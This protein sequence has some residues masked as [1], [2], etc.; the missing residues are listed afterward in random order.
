LNKNSFIFRATAGDQKSK[1]VSTYLWQYW[2]NWYN[3]S[4]SHGS[5]RPWD[6]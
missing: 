1:A 3:S 2:P 4:V 5:A 6:V